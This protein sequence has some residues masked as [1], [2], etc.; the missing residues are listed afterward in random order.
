MKLTVIIVNY[1]VKYY[2]EQCLNSLEKALDGIDSHIYV[3]D[4]HSK[5]GS[6]N[7]LSLHFKNIDLIDSN[8]N[9][10]F[11]RANNIAIRQSDSDYVL[12]LNPDTIVAEDTLREVVNF[13][14]D[15]PKVGGIGVRMQN[16]DGTLAMES[17]RGLPTPLTSFFKM[18]G[19]CACFPQ[20]RIFGRYY[21]SYL[22]WTE[23]Q[24]IEVISGAFCF[25]RRAAL[26]K[27]GLLDEDFFM[28]GEDI[29]LSYRLL[30]GG[31]ENWYLPLPI[32]HYKGESTHKSSF[33]YV[34]VFYQAMLIFFRK[35]YGHLSFFISLPIKIA[36]YFKAMIALVSMQIRKM[37]RGLGFITPR[38]PEPF[39]LFVGHK[40][41][42]SRC[43]AISKRKGLTAEF[44][45][46]D[47]HTFTISMIVDHIVN[48]KNMVV[49]V[50]DTD[51][52]K[53]Q[54]ML[55][56]MREI[57]KQNVYIGTFNNKTRIIITPNEIIK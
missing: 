25:L 2:V 31:F 20:S 32:L 40:Q 3:V 34:H 47:E 54:S 44:I 51:T 15:H 18:C 28:Y 48:N 23:P 10:G 37:R 52:F 17:R 4:N 19:L 46:A 1:N 30:K 13:M 9:L 41:M 42:I 6:V 16:A 49:V 39:Y 50:F 24:R 29:D 14:D 45:Y 36:I 12:L 7:Y 27:I 5:D 11:A 57:S 56:L 26:D 35:H 55:S 38:S 22:G 53:Y 8:H 43:Q 33:H 21:L